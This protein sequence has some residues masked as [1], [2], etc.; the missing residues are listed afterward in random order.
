MTF[1]DIQRNHPVYILDKSR[2]EVKQGKVTEAKPHINMQLGTVTSGNQP[3]RDVTIEVDG[4]QTV[5][6]IPEQLSVTFAND[7]VLATEQQGLT[8]EVEKMRN[9]AESVLQSVERMREVKARS[10]E[11]LAALNPAIKEKQETEKRF[12][13]IE[14]DIS[15]IKGMVKQLLDKL[16]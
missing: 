9:E 4:K 15:G 3:M 1:K 8:P 12:K 7:L 11:L 14:G 13:S 5:Y 6:T 2:V 16:G 10:E